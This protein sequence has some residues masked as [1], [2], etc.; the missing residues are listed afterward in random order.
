MKQRIAK[1]TLIA[2]T[3][4]LLGSL[5]V[6]PVNAANIDNIN[7]TEG[8]YIAQNEMPNIPK[9]NLLPGPDEDQD[10]GEVQDYFRNQAFPKFIEGFLG[11][12]A[13]LALLA[14]IGGGIQYIVAFGEEEA[15][16][17]ARKT[18]LWAILGF[19]IT[20]I[21]YAIVSIINT[22]AFPEGTYEQTDQEVIIYDDL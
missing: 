3:G 22:L 2:L 12:V 19:L 18:I 10:Q 7:E 9:P 1:F 20:L 15:M 14:V 6:A 5:W 21:A 4:L 16:T 17:K 13:A 8:R 11:L